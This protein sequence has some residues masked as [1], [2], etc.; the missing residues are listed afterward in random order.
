MVKN[1]ASKNIEVRDP[2]FPPI[3]FPPPP[4]R[5]PRKRTNRSGTRVYL[6]LSARERSTNQAGFQPRR[7]FA[8]KRLQPVNIDQARQNI[9]S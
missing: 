1:V 7:L 4:P 3:R 8:T 6:P 2:P 9:I 5:V